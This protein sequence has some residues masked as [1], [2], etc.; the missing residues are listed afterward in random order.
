MHRRG[1]ASHHAIFRLDA[2]ETKKRVE[3]QL[4]R[5]LEILP[6]EAPEAAC[7]P[8]ARS[9]SSEI[10]PLIEKQGNRVRQPK[11]LLQ[12]QLPKLAV[13]VLGRLL[14]GI[15]RPSHASKKDI[16]NFIV[17]DAGEWLSTLTASS[18]DF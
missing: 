14:S 5:G 4:K 13:G 8:L 1:I 12:P 15:Y 17:H 6:R 9:L 7:E 18:S 11:F 10:G 3:R 2:L 16:W